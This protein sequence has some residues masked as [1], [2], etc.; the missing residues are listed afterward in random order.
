MREFT[1]YF[2][3]ILTAIVPWDPAYLRSTTSV[4][5]A[6]APQGD[7]A[8]D[9]EALDRY[10]F[11]IVCA[12]PSAHDPRMAGGMGGQHSIQR[13]AILSF[14][15]AAYIRELGFQATTRPGDSTAIAMAAGLGGLDKKGRFV[16][17]GRG[18]GVFLT[19]PVLTDLPLA[20]DTR[21]S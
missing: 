16:T 9:L 10:A 5:A 2:G 14:N 20:P 1:A 17:D 19:N 8:D 13:G 11:V 12:I 6:D 18:K 21:S 7:E 4:S 15:L 3:A